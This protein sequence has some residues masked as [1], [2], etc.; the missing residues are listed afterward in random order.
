MDPGDLPDRRTAG[1]AEA[2]RGSAIKSVQLLKA[3]AA[4]PFTM[5]GATVRFTIPR[6]EDYEVAAITVEAR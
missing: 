4:V 5:D 2:A 1:S 3:E 6:I